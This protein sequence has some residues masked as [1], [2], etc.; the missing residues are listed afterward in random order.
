MIQKAAKAK[1]FP[2]YCQALSEGIKYAQ[3]GAAVQQKT[4]EA[5]TQQSGQQTLYTSLNQ[6]IQVSP[7]QLQQQV[8]Q[9]VQAKHADQT[10]YYIQQLVERA[11]DPTSSMLGN[12]TTADNTE[13]VAPMTPGQSTMPGNQAA[14][15]NMLQGTSATPYYAFVQGS[16][17][18]FYPSPQITPHLAR[19]GSS[20]GSPIKASQGAGHQSANAQQMAAFDLLQQHSQIGV[21]IDTP[22]AWQLAQQ[23]HQVQPQVYYPLPQQSQQPGRYYTPMPVQQPNGFAPTYDPQNHA[24]FVAQQ[25]RMQQD[26][27][28][29]QQIQQPG[30]LYQPT[31]QDNLNYSA[32]VAAQANAG[33][34]KRQFK[35]EDFLNQRH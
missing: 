14:F 33:N 9:T 3:H 2:V 10:P 27:I 1:A 4:Y 31:F 5:A 24:Q 7:Y 22:Q 13:Y 35:V 30:L 6:P 29:R 25:H 21:H 15:C 17:G 8:L 16:Q 26:Q 23:G 19:Q 11:I 18:A 28:Q 32:K 12:N 20:Y 34:P